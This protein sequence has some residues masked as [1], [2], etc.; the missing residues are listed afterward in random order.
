MDILP[1]IFVQ[2][3]LLFICGSTPD[4]LYE[5]VCLSIASENV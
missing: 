2:K 1:F 3:D 5:E 4:E